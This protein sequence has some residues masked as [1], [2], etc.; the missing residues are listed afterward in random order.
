VTT[1]PPGGREEVLVGLKIDVDTHRGLDE[2]VPRL[3]GILTR[4]GVPAS[5]YVTMGPD[6]SGRAILRAFRQPG[7]LSKMRRSRALRM[8][9]LRTALSGTLLPARPVGS[10]LPHRIREIEAAGFEAGIHGWDHVAWHDRLDRFAPEQVFDH[11]R[12][13]RDAFSEAMGHPP[14]ATAAPG[15]HATAESL[16]CQDRMGF[17]Y[18]SD[19]RGRVPFVPVTAQGPG[20]TIQIPTTLPT[21]DELLGRSDLPSEDPVTVWEEGIRHAPPGALAVITLHAEIEGMAHA[22]LL[23]AALRRLRDAGPVRFMRLDAVARA[24]DAATLPRRPIVRARIPGRA[25]WVTCAGEG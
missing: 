1:A 4:A 17:S 7:F 18:A 9:G 3:I 23:E 2:G 5:F 15:W 14:A 24:L 10:G 16:A 12:R 19:T 13:A 11:L 6:H 21:L 8:Y 20:G 25:G 22:A